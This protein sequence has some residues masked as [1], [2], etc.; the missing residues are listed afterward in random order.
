MLQYT[1]FIKKNARILLLYKIWPN[2]V[3][4]RAN[5][6][7]FCMLKDEKQTNLCYI[8]RKS[9]KPL[10]KIQKYPLKI[11]RNLLSKMFV[12]I[13]VKKWVFIENFRLWGNFPKNSSVQRRDMP[14][15]WHRK[16]IRAS[17]APTNL[18]LMNSLP[19]FFSLY[20][21]QN[22]IFLDFQ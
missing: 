8:I 13:S 6:L 19:S 12:I 18:L 7:K 11:E 3:N 21:E 5:W 20:L 17:L 10:N 4:F 14:S 1:L 15:A 2:S 16:N 22:N 9:L